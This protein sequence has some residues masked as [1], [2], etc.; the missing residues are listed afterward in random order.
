MAIGCISGL[1]IMAKASSFGVFLGGMGAQAMFILGGALIAS[2]FNSYRTAQRFQKYV[3]T[4]PEI[5]DE[6][7]AMP[8]SVPSKG[9]IP[10]AES[11][12]GV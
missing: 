4:H 6:V 12:A 11:A 10:E 2:P 8:S 3:E 5:L 9:S 1:I 7:A